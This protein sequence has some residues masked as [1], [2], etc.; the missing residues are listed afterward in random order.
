MVCLSEG[1]AISILGRKANASCWE[2]KGVDGYFDS[3]RREF[4]QGHAEETPMKGSPYLWP[5]H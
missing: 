1:G 5:G 2:L 3:H 4:R